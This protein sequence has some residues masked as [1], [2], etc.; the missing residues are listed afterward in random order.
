MKYS[1]TSD[2]CERCSRIGRWQRANSFSLHDRL[3]NAAYSLYVFYLSLSLSSSIVHCPLSVFIAIRFFSLGF[4]YFNGSERRKEK[5]RDDHRDDYSKW[6]V[7]LNDIGG[8]RF[9]LTDK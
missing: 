9:S 6:M 4:E 2:V 1:S 8:C 7:I 5:N 3:M